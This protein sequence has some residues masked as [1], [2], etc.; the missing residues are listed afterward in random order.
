M[1]DRI[2]YHR[3]YQRREQSHDEPEGMLKHTRKSDKE[4]K[5]RK[6]PQCQQSSDP[7]VGQKNERRKTE[8]QIN[9]IGLTEKFESVWNDI[10]CETLIRTE[11]MRG[12]WSDERRTEL[13]LIQDQLPDPDCHDPGC[14]A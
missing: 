8:Y 4:K 10:P 12:I 6:D 11:L 13:Y 2:Q 9:I 7:A 14:S 5:H 3:R 1:P